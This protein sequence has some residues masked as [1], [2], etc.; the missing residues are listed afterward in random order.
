MDENGR[1][2]RHNFRADVRAVLSV[3][4]RYG[5]I[6]PGLEA[7][8]RVVPRF[9]RPGQVVFDIGA[10]VGAYTWQMARLV[11]DEGHVYAF[12]PYP[13]SARRLRYLARRLG[14]RNV[15]V[16]ECAVTDQ[17]SKVFLSRPA[18]G[19]GGVYD[20]MVHLRTPAEAGLL[21][22]PTTTIDTAAAALGRAGPSFI[23][24]DAEGAEW[25]V[26]EGGRRTLS[27]VRPTV[28]CEVE[29]RWAGRYGHTRDEVIRQ[30]SQLGRSAPWVYERSIL[31]P[32]LRAQGN[33]N[34]VLFLPDEGPGA[35][36]PLEG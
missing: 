14:A 2:A 8:H 20:A 9:V 29:D 27:E 11:G 4:P 26:F 28:L 21:E 17:V 36:D 22:V 10:N 34:V 25:M 33:H 7:E 6:P 3:F 18:P 5:I 15:T 1:A 23:K 31:V 16:V 19:V 12:E 24:C 35:V 30:V 32:L 13:E